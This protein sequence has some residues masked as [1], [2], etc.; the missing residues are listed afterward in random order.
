MQHKA[1]PNG[2]AASLI[3]PYLDI[4]MA[5]YSWQVSDR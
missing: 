1:H 5:L 2:M 3:F 4:H